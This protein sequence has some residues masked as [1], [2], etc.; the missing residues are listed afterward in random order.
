[1]ISGEIL[2]VGDFRKLRVWQAAQELAVEAHR[3][4]GRMRGA[5]TAVLRDQ[6]MR[7]AM[8]VPTNIV[9]GSTNESPQEFCRF[10]GYSLRSASEAEGHAQLG[11]DLGMVTDPDFQSL[12]TKVVAVRMMLHGLIKKLRG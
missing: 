3:I 7:A 4:A 10:L 9:E 6:L 2:G 12:Q 8:S 5:R 1:V 11:R